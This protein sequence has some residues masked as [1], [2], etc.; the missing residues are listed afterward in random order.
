MVTVRR[1]LYVSIFP[2][3]NA[4]SVRN[5]FT[6]TVIIKD[7]FFIGDPIASAGF[8]LFPFHKLKTM[9]ECYEVTSC[10]KFKLK[11]TDT[12]IHK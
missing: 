5:W 7:W 1:A 8:S 4:K 6:S 12:L 2:W 3:W 11:F 10:C 9:R